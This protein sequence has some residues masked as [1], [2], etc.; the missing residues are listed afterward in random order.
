MFYTR[1]ELHG[2]TAGSAWSMILS[3]T[4]R[5]IIVDHAAPLCGS[6]DPGMAAP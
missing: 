6:A 1:Q 4:L 3:T 5:P 2:L